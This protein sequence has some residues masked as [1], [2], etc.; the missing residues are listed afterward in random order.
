MAGRWIR[1]MSIGSGIASLGMW[2]AVAVAM[3]SPAI[4]ATGLFMM[5]GIATAGTIVLA[6]FK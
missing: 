3:Y 6:F 1:Q 5:M 2:M 4:T